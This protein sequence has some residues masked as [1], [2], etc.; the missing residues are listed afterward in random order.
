MT[1]IT[2][3]QTKFIH[4]QTTPECTHRFVIYFPKQSDFVFYTEYVN[5][6]EP[7]ILTSTVKKSSIVVSRKKNPFSR[8]QTFLYALRGRRGIK[9]KYFIDFID[10]IINR[11]GALFIPCYV[12]FKF[13]R[14]QYNYDGPTKYVIKITLPIRHNENREIELTS[15]ETKKNENPIL[16]I[17]LLSNQSQYFVV[18]Q[19][20]YVRVTLNFT[21]LS[22]DYESTLK[23]TVAGAYGIILHDGSPTIFLKTALVEEK[24][25]EHLIQLNY[26]YLTNM[27][28]IQYILLNH[29]IKDSS[30]F[31]VPMTEIEE[32]TKLLTGDDFP[33]TEECH[34][35]SYFN[36]PMI[37]VSL[38]SIKL[39]AK[40]PDAP[41]L[42][43]PLICLL[44]PICSCVYC[45][46]SNSKKSFFA[47]T[48]NP[49]KK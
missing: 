48:V 25:E 34:S 23:D 46:N 19:T 3:K 45:L 5:E 7:Y 39:E 12:V 32:Q 6:N 8:L 31:I 21:L 44:L 33:C 4:T 9:T 28:S 11:K 30:S 13:T 18:T 29:K 38:H 22:P 43:I 37:M 27:S 35:F 41:N 15:V 17:H 16:P 36:K 24:E 20:A 26:T 47:A 49:K 42:I 40:K 2:N 10:H 14:S 1:L